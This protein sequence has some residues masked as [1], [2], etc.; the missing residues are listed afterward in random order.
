MDTFGQVY[1]VVLVVAL[2]VAV[3]G[4]WQLSRRGPR[5]SVLAVAALF[6]ALSFVIGPGRTREVVG[7]IGILRMI[8]FIGGILGIIDLVRSRKP[9]GDAPSKDA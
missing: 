4:F 6:Y 7:L 9:R 8:G 3:A 5:G 1:L 2:A